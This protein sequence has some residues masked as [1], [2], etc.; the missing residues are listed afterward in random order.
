[1]LP[2]FG[3]RRVSSPML[4]GDTGTESPPLAPLVTIGVETCLQAR[5]EETPTK[6]TYTSPEEWKSTLGLQVE[7][8]VKFQLEFLQFFFFFLRIQSFEDIKIFSAG[9]K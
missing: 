1:M 9:D 2:T 3:F 4:E 7:G 8:W 6:T 5:R